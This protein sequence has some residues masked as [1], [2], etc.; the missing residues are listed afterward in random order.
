MGIRSGSKWTEQGAPLD[1]DEEVNGEFGGELGY[2]AALSSDGDTALLGGRVDNSFHGAAWAFTRS[3]SMWTQDGAKL[4][5]SEETADREEFGWSVALSVH[6][7]HGS[8]GL[9]V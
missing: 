8:G 1:R 6:G 9:A 2:S 5:G 7:E 3:G 4:T